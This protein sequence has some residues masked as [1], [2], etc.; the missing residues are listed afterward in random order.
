MNKWL[1]KVLMNTIEYYY[2]V[3]IFGLTGTGGTTQFSPISFFSRWESQDLEELEAQ[4]P[5][6]I[7]VLSS[8]LGSETDF[9]MLS[10]LLKLTDN[11]NYRWVMDPWVFSCCC[12]WNM[13]VSQFF[14][15]SRK[16]YFS[17]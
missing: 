3:L 1:F 17:I 10:F 9:S 15:Y 16:T 13:P 12:Y 6:I 5:N 4:Y 11:N 8:T 2:L 14:S 7:W